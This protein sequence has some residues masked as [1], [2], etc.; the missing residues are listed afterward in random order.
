MNRRNFIVTSIISLITLLGCFKIKEAT[1]SE[2]LDTVKLWVKNKPDGKL[3]EVYI[4]SCI[5]PI[6]KALQ[7]ANIITTSSCCGHGKTNGYIVLGDRILE[8]TPQESPQQV[9]YRYLRDYE[10]IGRS[11]DVIKQIQTEVRYDE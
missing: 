2:H 9:E 4:D 10:Q 3:Y 7:D 8:V 6:V 1:A 5:A 11:W